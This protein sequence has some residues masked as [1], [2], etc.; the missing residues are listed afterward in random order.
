[1]IP[2]SVK[3]NHVTSST[4]NVCDKIRKD[5]IDNGKR[6]NCSEKQV[7]DGNVAEISVHDKQ[8]C[9]NQMSLECTLKMVEI[10]T[11]SNAYR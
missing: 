9:N 1:M 11:T 10:S 4:V 6:K 8:G 7:Y 5:N 3:F 2:T